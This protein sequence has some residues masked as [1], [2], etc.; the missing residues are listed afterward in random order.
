AFVCA[1]PRRAAS[2]PVP[3]A[4]YESFRSPIAWRAGTVLRPPRR[5][6]VRARMRPGPATRQAA[7][8]APEVPRRRLLRP[9]PTGAAAATSAPVGRESVGEPVW[10]RR[11]GSV[12]SHPLDPGP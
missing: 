4:P 9:E 10:A 5:G 1:A 3:P 11:A 2:R 12:A 8:P 7:N 6:A